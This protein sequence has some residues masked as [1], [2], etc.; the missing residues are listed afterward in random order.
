MLRAKLNET[1]IR[2]EQMQDNWPDLK[3]FI[4]EMCFYLYLRCMSCVHAVLLW[5]SNTWQI[6][7]GNDPNS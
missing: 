1:V 4:T 7:T 5:R 6:H 2:C 3:H